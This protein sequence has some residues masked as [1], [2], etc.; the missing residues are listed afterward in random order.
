MSLSLPHR[1]RGWFG[2]DRAILFSIAG[3]SW[4]L[5]S[6]PVT[7]LL[8]GTRLTKDEQGLFYNFFSLLGLQVFLELG[9]GQC[10][11]QFASHERAKL[12]LG[13]DHRLAGDPVALHRLLSLGRLSLTWYA[14]LAGLFLFL[15]GGAGHLFFSHH[16]PR[17]LVWISPWWLL[18][19]L[20]ALN[21][22]TQPFWFLIEGCNQVAFVNGYRL[23]VQV[24]ISLGLWTTLLLGGRLFANASAIAA[25]LSI[26]VA[27]LLLVWWPLVRQ[28]STHSARGASRVLLREIWPFQ[29]RMAISFASGYLIFS[30]FTPVMSHLQ[31]LEVGGQM[32]MTWQLVGA[33]NLGAAAWISTKAPRYGMLI[34]ERRFADLDALAR[35]VTLQAVS[36]S[37]AGGV[38]LLLCIAWLQAHSALGARFLD[39]PSTAMLVIATVVNQLITSQAFYLRAH[40]QEPFMWLSLANGVLVAAG[41]LILGRRYGALGACLAYA[42]VQTLLLPFSTA[43]FRS[44]RLGWH[45]SSALPS[46]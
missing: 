46:S 33:L 5:L 34:S 15:V 8:V 13:S 16:A 37:A 7:I 23:L 1:L 3:R 10:L 39:L 42:L 12:E 9:F 45:A 41:V 26:S 20:A 43:V 17:S 4:S 14:V 29:W 27:A 36:L 40:K 22:V 44:C 6:G 2:L 38:V 25:N 35:R 21:L 32:G 30:L 19:L 11:I 31:G 24:G 28:I 18:V